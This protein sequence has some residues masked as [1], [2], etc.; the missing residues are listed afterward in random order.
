ML[1]TLREG[2]EER[3]SF[4]RREEVELKRHAPVAARLE[5]VARLEPEARDARVPLRARGRG[6]SERERGRKAS[7]THPDARDLALR[8][9]TPDRAKTVGNVVRDDA[10]HRLTLRGCEREENVSLRRSTEGLEREE[11]THCSPLP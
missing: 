10:A 4:L 11:R 9:G 7:G 1:Q 6:E 8:I 3:V 2:E 5:Q